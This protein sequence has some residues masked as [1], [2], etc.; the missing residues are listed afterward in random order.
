MAPRHRACPTAPRSRAAPGRRRARSRDGLS[1]RGPS[2][3]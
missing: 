1:G 2:A 3:S